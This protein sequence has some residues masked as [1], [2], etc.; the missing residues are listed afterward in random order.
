MVYSPLG[1][2]FALMECLFQ[3][4]P[5]ENSILDEIFPIVGSTVEG[6]LLCSRSSFVWKLKGGEVCDEAFYMQEYKYMS[7]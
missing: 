7:F 3:A 1:D 4:I 2:D 5:R 6:V